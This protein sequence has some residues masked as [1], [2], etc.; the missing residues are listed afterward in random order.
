MTTK[1]PKS[2]LKDNV[3]GAISPLPAFHAYLSGD[4]TNALSGTSVQVALNNTRFNYGGFFDITTGRFTPTVPGL[5]HFCASVN[6]TSTN[7]TSTDV[8]IQKNTNSSLSSPYIPHSA[9]THDG[10]N[11]SGLF[12]MNGTTD[13]ISLRVYVNGDF[14]YTISGGSS[15]TYLTGYLIEPY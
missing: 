6:V 3:R 7:I 14:N 2:L 10:N 15:D 8:K 5:Y 11:V 12:E 13:Y 4:Q 9:R 1:T